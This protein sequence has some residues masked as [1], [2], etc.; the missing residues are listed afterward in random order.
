MTHVLT[1]LMRRE[2]ACACACAAQVFM[3]YL[4]L[5]TLTLLANEVVMYANH[6]LA[7]FVLSIPINPHT[8]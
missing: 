4:Y 7:F 2:R 1:P 3:G 8:K 6:L 5:H